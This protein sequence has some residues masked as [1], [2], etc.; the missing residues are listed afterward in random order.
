MSFTADTIFLPMLTSFRDDNK[1]TLKNICNISLHHEIPSCTQ[2]HSQVNK[3]NYHLALINID[4]ER[5]LFRELGVCLSNRQRPCY[6][7]IY[8]SIKYFKEPKLPIQ[9]RDAPILVV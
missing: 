1:L 5:Q 8:L 6:K 3:S 4:G 9:H 2:K 7:L